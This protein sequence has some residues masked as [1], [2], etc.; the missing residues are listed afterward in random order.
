MEGEVKEQ[1][2]LRD[3]DIYRWSWVNPPEHEPYWCKSQVAIAMNGV[4]RDTYW[5]SEPKPVQTNKVNLTYIGNVYE[6]TEITRGDEQ[7]YDPADVVDLRHAN[8]GRASVYVQPGAVRSAV[9]IAER[10]RWKIEEAQNTKR[11]AE[12]TIERLT[13]TL[14]QV[15]SGEN[16]DGLWF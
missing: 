8:A 12:N 2:E 7:Y 11:H 14:E 15:E 1:I 3:G 10:I 9:K 5:P 6:L 16:L 13:E 4:L